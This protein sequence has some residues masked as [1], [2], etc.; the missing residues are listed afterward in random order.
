MNNGTDYNRKQEELT[1]LENLQRNSWEPEVIISGITLAFLFVFP[2]KIYEFSAYLIQE[3]GIG[4][5]PSLLILFYLTTVVS[6]FKIFFVV[7][8]CLRFVWTGLL[9]LSYA[10]PDGVINKGLF[11]MSQR[12]THQKPADMVL[13]LE[14]LCSMTFA[15]PVSLVQVFLI[16]TIFIGFLTGLYFWF[17]LNYFIIFL[18]F[19]VCL[20]T[21]MALMLSKKK[22]KFKTWYAQNMLSSVSAIYQSNLGK[23]LAIV[24]ALLIFGLAI[25]LIISDAQD[26]TM[27]RNERNLIAKELEWPAKYLHFEDEHD[28]SMRYPRAFISSEEIEGNYLRLGVARYEGDGKIIDELNADFSEKLIS[29]SWKALN[30]TADLHR[31]Y[32]DDKLVKIDTWTKHRL[33][34]TKQKIYQTG[35]DITGLSSGVHTIRV[36][37]LLLDYGF[38]DNKAELVKIEQWDQFQFI[39][40]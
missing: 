14:K 35:I 30:Q 9:G 37:K 5:L 8:L 7:H 28:E 16:I 25:P 6:V 26:F 2:A 15:Y 19:I 31:I 24:Y 29:M 34:G 23:W 36:E 3:V 40:W 32:I 33:S 4:Y 39:K 1:W 38:V 21:F 13:K 18:L 11:K 22:S 10:F 20:I 12:Y 27:F 17:N